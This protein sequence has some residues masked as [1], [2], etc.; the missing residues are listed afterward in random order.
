MGGGGGG[1]IFLTDATVGSCRKLCGND[2]RNVAECLTASDNETTWLLTPLPRATV[3]EELISRASSTGVRKRDIV[4]SATACV[5]SIGP[6][7][8]N[9]LRQQCNRRLRT[10]RE[11]QS[12]RRF[13]DCLLSS[14]AKEQI[15]LPS[16]M[17][18]MLPY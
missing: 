13:T 4:L 15:H 7:S 14:P 11:I 17:L 18:R 10:V 9:S 12:L 3:A 2:C 1:I 6:L 8:N 5:I 16:H